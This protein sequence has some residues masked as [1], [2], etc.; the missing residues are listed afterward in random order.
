MR[1]K[2]IASIT[3]DDVLSNSGKSTY[4]SS[5]TKYKNDDVRKTI[6]LR[7]AVSKGGKID[8]A[9]I[10]CDALREA[11]LDYLPVRQQAFQK[12]DVDTFFITQKGTAF[13]PTTMA[14]KFMEMSRKSGIEFSSHSG[15]RTL[16]TNLVLKGI[17]V[18]DIQG[19]MRH[20]DISTTMLYFQKDERRLGQLMENA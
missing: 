11:L 18:F 17:N 14:H 9:F 20:A 3:L 8:K 16:C 1:A 10:R 19:I 4:I 13:S 12:G 15:R 6:T 2:E 5:K 7:S